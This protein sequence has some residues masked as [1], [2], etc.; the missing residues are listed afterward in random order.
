MQTGNKTFIRDV[1][2]IERSYL[3][4]Y[5][6]NFYRV[7]WL[8]H[9]H[10]YLPVR[11][12]W[13]E[14]KV[15]LNFHQFNRSLRSQRLVVAIGIGWK[16]RSS[17]GGDMPL[18]FWAISWSQDFSL[19][20]IVSG[21]VLSSQ[22]HTVNRQTTNYFYRNSR[23]VRTQSWSSWPWWPLPWWTRPFQRHHPGCSVPSLHPDSVRWHQ[24][25]E[26]YI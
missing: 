9:V 25:L 24:H 16:V 22:H 7:Q 20:S 2:K 12:T 17:R 5:A 8:V 21:W 15:I 19:F 23:N 26:W 18:P 3:T 10:R 4:E 14:G 11:Y 13:I 6:P 1:T